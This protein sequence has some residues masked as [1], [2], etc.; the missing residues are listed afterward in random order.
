MSF[1]SLSSLAS[2]NIRNNRPL[3]S[4]PPAPIYKNFVFPNDVAGVNVI[5][6]PT[7]NYN[8]ATG[9][10]TWRNGKYLM[11]SKYYSPEYDDAYNMFNQSTSGFYASGYKMALNYQTI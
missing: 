5:T 11:M 8:G 6:T 7:Y 3:P 9:E 2:T 10:N 4:L 1:S